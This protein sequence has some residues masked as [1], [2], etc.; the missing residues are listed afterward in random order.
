MHAKQLRGVPAFPLACTQ[1]TFALTR[2]TRRHQHQTQRDIR[3]CIRY[4][5][6]RVADGN[7]C[8]LC[9]VNIYMIVPH[10]EVCQQ[11]AACLPRLGEDI[12]RIEI[13]QSGHHG[14][15]IGQ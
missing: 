1:Q 7:P 8:C 15:V 12:C 13:A 3:R 6:G 2:A 5:T 9:R 11:L 14:V 4:S 10:T